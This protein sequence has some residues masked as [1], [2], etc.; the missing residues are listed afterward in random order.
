MERETFIENCKNL[1]KGQRGFVVNTEQRTEKS[2]MFIDIYHESIDPYNLI[3]YNTTG[4]V[5]IVQG[6]YFRLGD[7]DYQTAWA[8]LEEKLNRMVTHE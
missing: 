4:D 3:V 2:L 7:A 8:V 6:D 1:R 5:T